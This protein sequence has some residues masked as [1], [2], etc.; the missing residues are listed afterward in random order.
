M[1]LRPSSSGTTGLHLSGQKVACSFCYVFTFK[2]SV[3]RPSPVEQARKRSRT[4]HDP[5]S[6]AQTLGVS[7]A[8]G[9]T[10]VK[11]NDAARRVRRTP[12][13]GARSHMGWAPETYVRVYADLPARFGP[14]LSGL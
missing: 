1:L 8:P 3:T 6:R 9:T 10:P 2:S 7:G 5:A 11:M 14:R 4:G 12:R 13:L